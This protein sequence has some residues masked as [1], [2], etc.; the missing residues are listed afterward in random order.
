MVKGV[1]EACCIVVVVVGVAF[2]CVNQG[3]GVLSL[4]IDEDYVAIEVATGNCLTSKAK[5]LRSLGLSSGTTSSC[6]DKAT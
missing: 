2:F 5:S 1:K 6:R 4:M 3:G